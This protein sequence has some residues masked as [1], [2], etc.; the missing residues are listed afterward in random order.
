MTPA[1][2]PKRYLT[3]AH[4]SNIATIIFLFSFIFINATRLYFFFFPAYS[5]P[6]AP[7]LAEPRRNHCNVDNVST[8]AVLM[9]DVTESTQINLTGPENTWPNTSL[10]LSQL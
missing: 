8:R 1:L 2:D 5:F 10:T 9:C 4:T 3:A 7:A 6:V